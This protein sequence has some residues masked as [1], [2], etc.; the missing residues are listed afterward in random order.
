MKAN[1]NTKPFD[2]WEGRVAVPLPETKPESVL[3][4]VPALAPLPPPVDA[5]T[6]RKV[7]AIL[8][9]T[10]P[11]VPAPIIIS[12]QAEPLVT[13]VLE[14]IVAKSEPGNETPVVVPTV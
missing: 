4:P 14:Q 9:E 8:K 12:Q 1:T 7:I 2:S 3:V 11:A 13:P 10:V 5:E 6:V